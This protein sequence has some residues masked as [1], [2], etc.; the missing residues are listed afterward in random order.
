MELT[1]ISQ[2][3]VDNAD[4]L[5]R[6][7]SSL[8]SWLTSVSPQAWGSWGKFDHRQFEEE[9]MAKG[10]FNPLDRLKHINIKQL[11]A[12][13]RKHRVGLGRALERSNMVF[14]GR[15]HSGIADA[16]NIARLIEADELLRGAVLQRVENTYI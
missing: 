11:F 12:R 13:K 4:E 7:L 14:E 3:Q 15:Q 1:G 16:R 6:V 5:G 9:T 2:K 8:Q 10:L